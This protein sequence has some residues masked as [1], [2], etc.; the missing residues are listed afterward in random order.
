MA[1]MPTSALFAA[2][3]PLVGTKTLPKILFFVEKSLSLEG[4]M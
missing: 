2:F 1:K 4:H 3:W